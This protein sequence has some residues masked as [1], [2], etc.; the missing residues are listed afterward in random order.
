MRANRFVGIL[1]LEDSTMAKT[2]QTPK[3]EVDATLRPYGGIPVVEKG[4][5]EVD[6]TDGDDQ[7]VVVDTGEKPSSRNKKNVEKRPVGATVAA[8]GGRP[9]KSKTGSSSK[10]ATN[11]ARRTAPTA[12]KTAAAKKPTPKG[13]KP[14]RDITVGQ[15]A[16]SYLC[17]L[18]A[19][20]KSR[21][22]VFSYGIELKTAVKHFGADTR[23][24]SL[25]TKQVREYFEGDAVTKNRKGKPKSQLTIDKTRRVF[26]FAV[27]WLA[28]VG[29]IKDPPIPDLRAKAEKAAKATATTKTEAKKTTKK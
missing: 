4:V 10:K 24:A 19:I 13:K 27:E 22:T 5:T 17:H 7:T 29:V 25:T 11:T 12:A 14:P 16:E 6:I 20:G 21:G 26:R 23:A 2:T 15:L 9:K 8:Q 28:E 1:F 18:E 3:S